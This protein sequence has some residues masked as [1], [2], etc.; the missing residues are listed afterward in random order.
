L[1]ERSTGGACVVAPG[2]QVCTCFARKEQ[3]ISPRRI[4]PMYAFTLA[5]SPCATVYVPWWKKQIRFAISGAVVLRS[6]AQ[7]VAHP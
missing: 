7:G 3:S 5:W 4:A 2:E 1:S 6:V